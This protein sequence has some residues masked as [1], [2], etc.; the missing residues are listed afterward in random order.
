MDG[1]FLVNKR[2]GDSSNY[3]VQ[4]AKKKFRANKVG[5]LGTLDPL[6]SGLLILAVNRATK[7]SSY[8]LE[9]EK[10][11]QVEIELGIS[12]DT[13]DSTGK[14]ISKSNSKIEE[15]EVKKEL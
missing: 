8:F 14:I 1:F 2:V 6:A 15:S 12:T 10:F 13:D 9:S 3:V 5:H 4:Q 11:Y 7:F